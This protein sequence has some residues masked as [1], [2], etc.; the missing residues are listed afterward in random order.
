MTSSSHPLPS[1]KGL[2][3]AQDFLEEQRAAAL[4]AL[5]QGL[6]QLQRIPGPALR[7]RDSAALILVDE[8]GPEP[9]ILLGRRNPKL[10]FVPDVFVFPGGAVEAL[11][12][13]IAAAS[14]LPPSVVARLQSHAPG[15]TLARARA[16][17]LAAIRELAEETG[18]LLGT[19]GQPA[20][21]WPGFVE[22]GIVP[23]LGE[24]RF[25]ARAVTPPG[26]VRRYDT[27]F[28]L[29]DASEIVLELPGIVGRD[30]ELVE[31]RWATLAEAEQLPMLRI[32]RAIAYEVARGLQSAEHAVPVPF[33]RVRR[34]R[35]VRDR[36]D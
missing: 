29:A 22:A 34:G 14:E 10:R 27:R 36:I 21:P 35:F 11:D 7:P 3:D 33:F 4:A 26:M 5:Q 31:L 13:R 32:T 20:A 1:P 28:F 2:P 23:K 15:V 12:R 17:A 9:R 25:V 16:F 24:L 8:N 19:P 6:K 18:L 30:S